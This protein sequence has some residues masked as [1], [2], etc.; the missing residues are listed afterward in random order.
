V[1][2]PHH[3]R[4]ITAVAAV[5]AL[6]SLTAS[7]IGVSPVMA[8][9][10]GVGT[11]RA[12]EPVS[13]GVAVAGTS[14]T[15]ST[16]TTEPAATDGYAFMAGVGA[17]RLGRIVRMD[18]STPTAV[19]VIMRDVVNQINTASSAQLVIGPDTTA[20]PTVDEIV[21]RVPEV[22]VCGPLAAGCASNSIG[23]TEGIGVVTNAVIEI[24][25]DLLGSGYEV[26][27]LL[28]EMGHA[29]GL[30]HYDVPYRT[31]MQVMWN[32][33]TPDMVAYR[34]GDR[35]GL[36]ALTAAFANP[37]V[38]GNIDVVRQTPQGIRV[39][40]W[41]LDLDEPTTAL[42]VDA[43]INSVPGASGIANLYRPD[44]GA[45]FAGAGNLHGFDML[46]PTPTAEG[47]ANICVDAFGHRDQKVSVL[48]RNLNVSHR[49]TGNLDVARQSG[50][51][52]VRVSGWAL[53]PDTADP[54]GVH[55]YVNDR[56]AQGI[57]ANRPRPD[58]ETIFRGYGPD[59][60]FSTELTGMPGGSNRVCA[61]GIDSQGGTNALLACR[62]VTVTSGNPVG[63]LEGPPSSWLLPT[64]MTGWALDPDTAA[65]IDVHL[66]VDG[67]WSGSVRA[68]GIRRDVAA[69]F[70][71]YGEAH[72]FALA[73]PT[74]RPGTNRA[75]VYAINVGPGSTNP[76]IGCRFITTPGGVP[77]GNFEAIRIVDGRLSATGWTID[78]DTASSIDVHLY[79]DGRFV[80][81]VTA[82]RPRPD[83][84]AAFPGYLD[85]HGFSVPLDTV[86]PGLRT[87]C[88]YAINA[89]TGTYNPNLGCK[90]AAIS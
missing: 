48:C 74:L 86:A 57:I 8:S 56:F 75:C 10:A 3:H 30:G 72:G 9:E 42:A 49:P 81:S 51:T 55:I 45:A 1:R 18:P 15:P 71:G 65:P 60:G 31:Q 23:T 59:H 39:I 12:A 34:T 79:V 6:F 11:N 35:N 61:Y 37:N 19:R 38:T 78:P 4:F 32:S 17:T 16:E 47:L 69:A 84:A 76:L 40:G 90:Q 41:T 83:V 67:R 24:K 22:T 46:V 87:V 27:I 82:D 58:V 5:I 36:A 43:T 80:S 2:H 62:L 14:A 64:V 13:K 44:V 88:V 85:N 33:V 53:D 21:V 26:P 89:A 73:L 68:D 77:F 20:P 63:N 28:H 25:R 50:P 29:M 54:I 7:T 66:Y 52:T 70:P